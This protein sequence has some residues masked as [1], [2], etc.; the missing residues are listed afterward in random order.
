MTYQQTIS[1]ISNKM[2][3]L[4]IDVAEQSGEHGPCHA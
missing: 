2:L 1:T 4:R 3:T